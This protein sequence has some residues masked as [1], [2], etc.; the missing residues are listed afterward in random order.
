MVRMSD[1]VK[2]WIIVLFYFCLVLFILSSSHLFSQ[3]LNQKKGRELK[4]SEHPLK[5]QQFQRVLSS[6]AAFALLNSKIGKGIID[7]DLVLL[8][9]RDLTPKYFWSHLEGARHSPWRLF[10]KGHRSGELLEL[11]ALQFKIRS[12]GIS[13]NQ[14]VIIYGDWLDGWGEEARMLWLLEYL[15]HAK[16]F[17]VEGGWSV[18]KNTG[19]P[20]TWGKSPK[21]KSSSWVIEPH[22]EWRADTNKVVELLKDQRQSI[23]ARSEKEYLG[24]TPYGSNYG[25]HFKNSIHLPWKSLLDENGNLYS[26]DTL[27]QRFSTLG[28]KPNEPIFTYCTG[29]IRSSF[30]YLAL[31]EAGYDKVM[32]YDGSW[33]AWSSTYPTPVP[34]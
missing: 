26:P 6:E 15:G 29:G 33:W 10:T 4:M 18:L 17:V 20:L 34:P 7:S 21:V 23:D 1:R 2:R 19:L 32:N 3:A 27:K 5:E 16:V 24:K 14:T 12:L 31:R 11:D 9:A 28:L 30:I 13:N 25:G 22:T 8:D